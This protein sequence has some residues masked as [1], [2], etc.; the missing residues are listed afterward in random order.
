MKITDQVAK[1]IISRLLKSQDYRIE[2]INILNAEFLQFTIDFFKKIIIAKLD[3]K[4]ITIDWYKE[5]FL[6][7]DKIPSDEIIIN[8]GLN[9]KTISN[10]Y[11]S[12][13]KQ[14][15]IDASTEHFF[16]FI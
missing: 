14:I 13:S 1:N 3:S 5:N 6:S 9:K 11:G 16:C 12:A 8:S 7:F 10:M 15:V 4:N 2:I